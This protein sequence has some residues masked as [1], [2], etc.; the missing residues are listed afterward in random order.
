V[1]ALLRTEFTKAIRRGRTLAIGIG[2]VALPA[3]IVVAIHARRNRPERGD[4]GEGLFRL[5]HL[6]GLLVPA[7]VLEVMSGFLLVV[8][9]AMFAGDTIAGDA[10][11][12]NLR[13]VLM[14]P[15]SRARL[16]LAKALVAGTM[17]WLCTFLVSA[18]AL[19]GGIWLFGAH[20]LTVPGFATGN[21]FGGFTLSTGTLLFRLLVATAYVA[22]GYSALLAIGTFLSVLTDTPAG[23]I[24]AT[25][26]VYIVSEILD[27]IS[28]FGVLRYGLPTHYLSVWNAMFIDNRYPHDMV[29]GVIVQV[30]Y[31]VVFG[32]AALVYFGR[33]DIRS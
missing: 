30:I 25:I 12:G 8:I 18:A 13:Y 33:K 20:P 11:W 28:Q 2:L 7:A 27:G 26:A 22:F 15:V 1:I 32:G 16:L 10:A 6:T 5:A 31:L 4:T 3:L 29:T 19:V 23:A 21:L 24:G 14:R 17:I 9:A